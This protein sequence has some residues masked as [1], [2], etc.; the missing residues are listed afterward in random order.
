MELFDLHFDLFRFSLLA[1]WQ[2]DH[3]DP[4]L[5]LCEDL[6]GVDKSGQ[7]KASKELAISALNTMKIL[8]LDF[9]S[10]LPLAS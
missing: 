5:E 3:Q 1:F 6:C 8:T 4:I 7:R 2:G 10:E 9:I